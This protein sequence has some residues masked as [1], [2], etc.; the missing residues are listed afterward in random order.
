MSP[1][2]ARE[3]PT[4]WGMN[5]VKAATSVVALPVAAVKAN[6]VAW[7]VF[8]L[9]VAVVVIRY[10]MTIVEWIGKAPGGERVVAF[11]TR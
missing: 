2:L 10:R 7:G 4:L 3:R 1:A 11:T 5:P 9:I 8:F 6:P